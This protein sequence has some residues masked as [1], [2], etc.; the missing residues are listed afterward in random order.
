MIAT[1]VLFGMAT[2]AWGLQTA[3]AELSCKPDASAKYSKADAVRYIHAGE[4][5]WASSVA[6]SDTSILK[7]ILSDDF[8]WVLDDRVLDKAAAIREA[9]QG[10]GKYLS[11][12]LDYAHV[13]FFGATAVVQGR[14]HWVKRNPRRV[15]HFIWTDTWILCNGAWKIVNS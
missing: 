7:R 3:A 2:T 1:S 14:E 10:P 11:N 13:R 9:A 15:G 12:Q 4:A 5:E 8:V 6:T